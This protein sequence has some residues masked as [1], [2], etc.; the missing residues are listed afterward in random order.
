MSST[1]WSPVSVSEKSV[2]GFLNARLSRLAAE[3]PGSLPDLR[4]ARTLLI[5]SDYS[6]ESH[7]SRHLVFSFLLTT[8]DS[9]ADWESERVQVRRAHLSNAR[10]M[11]FKGLN[12][13]QRRRA[14]GPMLLAANRLS[15][16][17]LSVALNKDESIFNARPPLDLKNPEFTAYRQWKP[18]VLD[19]AFV[20]LHI[21]GLLLGGLATQGQDVVWF[22]DEDNIAPNDQRVRELTQL[23]AWVVSPYLSF[24]LGHLRCGTSRCDDGSRQIEDFLAIPDLVAGA[25]SEQMRLQAADRAQGAGI[26]WIHRGDF[27]DKSRDI[28]WWL[29]DARQPL[30]RLF[31]LVDPSAD[32]L[33][34]VVS[35]YHFRDV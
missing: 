34:H 3:H 13:G 23:F 8:L 27:T 22:T 16:L 2:I 30:N 19:K 18:A 4:S 10:R 33:G 14:M 15:G 1:R 9:W 24:N 32:Q 6:G 25:L 5:G 31:V 12:D 26:F 35:L 11:S 20:A 29:S 28:T 17:S 7:D 21:L